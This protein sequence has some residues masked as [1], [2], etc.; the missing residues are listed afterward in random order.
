MISHRRISFLRGYNKDR[1]E[2]QKDFLSEDFYRRNGLPNYKC[3]YDDDHNVKIMTEEMVDVLRKWIG[4]M[5]LI[6][7]KISK[8]GET[9][10]LFEA[11]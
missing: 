4:N 1:A 5:R 7:G 6:S 2:F 8:N 9:T 10:V 11:F 3:E